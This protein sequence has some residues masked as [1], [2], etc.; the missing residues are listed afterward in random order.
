MEDYNKY[1]VS[2]E[3]LKAFMKQ[4][5]SLKLLDYVKTVPKIPFTYFPGA[6]N[7]LTD[8]STFNCDSDIYSEFFFQL[9]QLCHNIQSLTIKFVNQVSNGLKELISSQNNLKYLT[10]SAY[11]DEDWGNVIPALKRHHNTLISLRIYCD[12]EDMPLSFIALFV[13]LQELVISNFYGEISFKEF[14]ELQHVAFSRL[15]IFK[16]PYESPGAEILMRFLENN[17]KTLNELN[18]DGINKS[19]KSSV[20]QFCPNLKKLSI[21]LENDE[22]NILKTI[23]NN[24]QHLESI[25]IWC[26]D[27]FLDE[28][29]MLEVVAKYS[30]QNFHELKVFNESPSELLSKDLE[31]FLINWGNRLPQKPLTLIVNKNDFSDYSLGVNEENIATIEKYKQL[32]IIKKFETKK[33]YVEE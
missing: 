33:F 5:S 15:R 6:K 32:G 31:S 9:S 17:G 1:L 25:K 27:E 29:E 14:N 4:I 8:L 3:L 23:F 19:L 26:G 18:I 20:A 16:I 22:M 28:K 24:C 21:I 12:T 11:E 30:P 13:N 7:C 2:Q 10:L